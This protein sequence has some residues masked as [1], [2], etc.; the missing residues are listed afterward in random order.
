MLFF[1]VKSMNDTKIF[2]DVYNDF[3]SRPLVE[4]KS[5]NFVDDDKEEDYLSKAGKLLES[6]IR[7]SCLKEQDP[8]HVRILWRGADMLLIR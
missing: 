1:E 8:G 3:F 4:S 2:E 5:E 6:S 7:N